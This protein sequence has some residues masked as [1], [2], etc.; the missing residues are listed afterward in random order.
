LPRISRDG[1][2]ASPLALAVCVALLLPACRRRESV[3][4]ARDRATEQYLT[5]EI[6]DLQE[7]IA[8]AESGELVTR[9][10]IAI[11]IA[12]EVVKSLIDASLPQ[13]QWI[14]ERVLVRIEKGQAFFRGNNAGLL[15]QGTA[16]GKTTGATARLEL[17]GHL[18]DLRLHRGKLLANVGIGHFKVVGT[19]VGDLAADVV[20]RLMRDNADQLTRL[21]PAIAI[22]VSFEEAI[23]VPGLDEGVVTAKAGVL[24]L[25]MTVAETIPVNQRL[26]ILLD[27]KAGPWKRQTAAAQKTTAGLRK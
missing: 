4:A 1:A 18:E 3:E 5:V 24:P 14:A 27:V 12:E 6:A 19:S 11:G 21:I 20:E 15:F 22:P 10:R 17:G 8:R 7:L 9:D 2:F 25:E 26:W 23:E 13:E 16:T